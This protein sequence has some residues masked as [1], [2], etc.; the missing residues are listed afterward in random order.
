MTGYKLLVAHLAGDYVLQTGWMAGEKTKRWAPA[1]AHAAAY[2]LPFLAVTRSP[3][4]L[5]VIGGTHAVIDRYR[6]AGHLSWAKNQLAPA[7]YRYTRASGG[8]LGVN[9]ADPPHISFWVG[10]AV[11]NCIH[12]T[13]NGIAARWL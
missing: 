9:P 5:A 3:R 12:L 4:A 1:L 8:P 10:I 11:D 2:T 6:L 13:L 7:R